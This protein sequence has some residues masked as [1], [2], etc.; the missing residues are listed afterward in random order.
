[1]NLKT[2]D[3]RSKS[4]AV[5]VAHPDDE[6]LWAGGTILCHPEWKWFIVCL[7]R[8]SD[9]DRSFKFHEA[10]KILKSEGAIGDM[11]DGPEQKPLDENEVES[12]ILKLLPAKHF[13]LIITHSPFGEYTRHRRHEEAGKAV[14]KLWNTGK[15]STNELWTFAYSDYNKKQLPKADKNAGISMILSNGIWLRKYSLISETYGFGESSFEAETTPRTESFRQFTIPAAA[16]K[17][18]D[19][20]MNSKI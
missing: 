12:A 4:V 19:E 2:P 5:I 11:D 14:I 9:K 15:I 1:M 16:E 3:K 13:D 20:L 18:L 17:W 10:L 8:E 7:S 6:T